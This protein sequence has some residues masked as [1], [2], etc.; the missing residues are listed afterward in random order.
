VNVYRDT[1]LEYARQAKRLASQIKSDRHCVETA[2]YLLGG[3][4]PSPTQ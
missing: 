1:A 3:G 4:F 2:A